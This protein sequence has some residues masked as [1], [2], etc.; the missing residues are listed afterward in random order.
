MSEKKRGRWSKNEKFR[1]AL[2]AVHGD[3]TIAQIAEENKVHPI[4][5]SEWKKQLLEHSADVFTTAVN[6]Q[7][8]NNEKDHDELIQTIGTQTVIIEWLK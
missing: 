7:D 2:A 5:V 8:K 4:Q 6:Q 3:K 1:I